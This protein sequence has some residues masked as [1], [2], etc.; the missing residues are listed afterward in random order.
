MEKEGIPAQGCCKK[1]E[2]AKLTS[3]QKVK[4]HTIDLEKK[5][6]LL[7]AE[8]SFFKE[9][10]K[11]LDKDMVVHYLDVEKG[12]K[13]EMDI[14]HEKEHGKQAKPSKPAMKVTPEKKP[15]I[16]GAPAQKDQFRKQ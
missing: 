8:R 16:K 11:S 7:A 10:S 5:Q 6:A 13:R 9:I 14:R 2:P 1:G 4:A 3:D 12:F 15:S